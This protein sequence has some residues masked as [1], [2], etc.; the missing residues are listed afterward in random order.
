[1]VLSTTNAIGWKAR[2]FALKGIDG[3]TYSLSDV[4]GRKGT[5]VVFICNHCPYVKASI[6]RIVAEAK[7]LRELGIG[8]IAIMPNDTESYLEDSF[9][10]MKAFAAKH[11]FTFP[12]V[13]DT[14]QQVARAY[15]AQCTPDFF[16]FNAQDELQYRGRL[17]A[18]RMT[19]IAN[20]RRD[21][22]EAMKQIA[23][24]GHGPK[25]QFPSMGCSIKWKH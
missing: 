4:R 18:S 21:L 22:Y 10:N 5:V 17:D 7:T 23:E 1:M 16:G 11:G 9:D 20:A 6:T 12:Y 25:E 14:S 15:D 2:D 3:K 8:T 13:I 19:P 24:T